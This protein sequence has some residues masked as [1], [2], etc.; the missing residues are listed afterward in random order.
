MS[1]TT[2]HSL[3]AQN[4]FQRLIYHATENVVPLIGL[5]RLEPEWTYV[6]NCNRPAMLLVRITVGK[7]KIGWGSSDFWAT[8][9][10]TYMKPAGNVYTGFRTHLE[11]YPRAVVPTFQAY[12]SGSLSAV[13]PWPTSITR[14]QHTALMVSLAPSCLIA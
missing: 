3:P 11:L 2:G 14:G 8:S 6:D 4:S 5:S 13:R 7:I 9:H 10:T 12:Q 1:G